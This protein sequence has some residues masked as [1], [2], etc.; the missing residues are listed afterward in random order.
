[1][2]KYVMMCCEYSM[3]SVYK[4]LVLTSTVYIMYIIYECLSGSWGGPHWDMLHMLP[5]AEVCPVRTLTEFDAFRVSMGYV[6]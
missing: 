4:R 1:M 5:N 2:Q 3:Q 6:V